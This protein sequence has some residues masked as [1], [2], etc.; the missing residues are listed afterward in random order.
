MSLPTIELMTNL[1]LYGQPTKPS[2][3]VD[4]VLIRPKSETLP[5]N[6]DINEYMN[7]PGRFATLDKFNIV[8]AFF[9]PSSHPLTDNNI[10]Q[11]IYT[12]A[13]LNAYYGF[14][15]I[16]IS[17]T[18]SDYGI[19]DADF[20]TRAYIWQSTAFKLSDDTLFE[21]RADGSRHM[22]LTSIQVIGQVQQDFILRQELTL[23]K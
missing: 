15:E 13:Q 9:D 16:W 4:D 1:Y 20:L 17:I 2:N 23:Q 12:K 10:P 18:Q 5:F 7:G 22:Y 11:G 3:L 8:Q 19:G 21:V 14:S 6:V